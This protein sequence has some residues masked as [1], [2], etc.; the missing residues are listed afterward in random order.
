V[1]KCAPQSRTPPKSSAPK[2][3]TPKKREVPKSN[4][5]CVG[6]PLKE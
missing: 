2:M 3:S 6:I 4:M 1:Y 5:F